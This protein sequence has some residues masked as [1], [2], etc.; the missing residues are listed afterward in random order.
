MKFKPVE[1]L[2]LINGN[3]EHHTQKHPTE[4]LLGIVFGKPDKSTVVLELNT[5]HPAYND[6][7][8]HI[9]QVI[10]Y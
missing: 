7:S 10:G 4:M 6:V 8:K 9:R 5:K 2:Y 3:I 1:F